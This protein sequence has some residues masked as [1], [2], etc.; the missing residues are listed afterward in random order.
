VSTQRAGDALQ[1]HRA[2]FGRYWAGGGHDYAELAIRKRDHW[3][4]LYHAAVER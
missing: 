1:K 4:P 3:P 2:F